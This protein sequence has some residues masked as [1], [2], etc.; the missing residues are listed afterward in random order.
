M[1]RL[2]VHA[3]AC[4]YDV[5]VTVEKVDRSTV[6]V[7]L[8]SECEQISAMQPDISE[9]NWRKGVFCRIAE[10]RIY[11]SAAQHLNHAAC[12]V[13]GAILKA[14]EVEVGIALPKDILIHF[15]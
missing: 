15:E 2:I 5:A 12:P 9:L 1:T 8:N 6:R 10:S 4:G 7:V 3:G 14:I 13:P 11:Q